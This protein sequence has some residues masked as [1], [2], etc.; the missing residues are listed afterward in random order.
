MDTLGKRK[1]VSAVLTVI[2]N[3]QHN[4]TYIY[5]H[6]VI[7]VMF[8]KYIIY[9]F[10]HN[11]SDNLGLGGWGGSNVRSYTYIYFLIFKIFICS[12]VLEHTALIR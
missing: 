7:F 5:N 6:S 9:T 3:R 1:L 10:S 4:L 8:L 2:R 12:T 11:H